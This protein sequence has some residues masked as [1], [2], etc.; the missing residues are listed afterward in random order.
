ME[1]RVMLLINVF[2]GLVFLALSMELRAQNAVFSFEPTMKATVL[3]NVPLIKGDVIE[4]NSENIKNNEKLILQ[5]CGE[6]CNTAKYIFHWTLKDFE[7]SESQ[8]IR[9]EE[10]GQYYFWIQRLTK[11][12][13]VGPVFGKHETIDG[14]SVVLY[15][16]SGTEVRIHLRRGELNH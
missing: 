5:R 9:L 7:L 2:T 4:V 1:N 12:G 11:N 13:E 8:S 14:N 10:S 3:S 15:F 6:P 16:S